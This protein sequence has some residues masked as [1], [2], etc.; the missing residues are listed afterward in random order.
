[1][2]DIA[3]GRQR[4][5][6]GEQDWPPLEIP[7]ADHAIQHVGRV[8]RVRQVAQL[9]DDEHVRVQVGL[10]GSVEPQLRTTLPAEHFVLLGTQGKRLAAELKPLLIPS[11]NGGRSMPCARITRAATEPWRNLISC[12]AT[13]GTLAPELT[14]A[15]NVT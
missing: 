13:S 10:E 14:A 5:V 6:G 12:P 7:V 4:F 1:M 2:H 11:Q 9:V 3:R 8:G 15:V